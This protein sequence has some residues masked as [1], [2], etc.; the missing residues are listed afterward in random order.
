MRYPYGQSDFFSQ[1]NHHL[2]EN[3]LLQKIQFSDTYYYE[4]VECEL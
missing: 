4:I 3:V 2:I 1:H